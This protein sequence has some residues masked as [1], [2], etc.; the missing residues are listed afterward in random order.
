MSV[1]H[2][3]CDVLGRREPDG[4]TSLTLLEL[5]WAEE[6]ERERSVVTSV[7]SAVEDLLYDVI[8]NIVQEIVPRE[9]EKEIL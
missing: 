6:I 8:Y 4:L 5:D 9:A 2:T 1:E 7:E 3:V